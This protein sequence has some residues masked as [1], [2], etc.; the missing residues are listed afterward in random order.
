MEGTFE[1]LETGCV[2]ADKAHDRSA[3][4]AGEV[5]ATA[6]F[7]PFLFTLSGVDDDTLH[8]SSDILLSLEA[9]TATVIAP[10]LLAERIRPAPPP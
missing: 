9:L 2:V 3:V 5:V 4:T 7:P 10:S 1:L 8:E 6:Q